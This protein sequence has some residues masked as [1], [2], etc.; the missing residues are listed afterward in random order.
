MF[1]RLDFFVKRTQSVNGTIHIVSHAKIEHIEFG[2]HNQAT[3]FRSKSFKLNGSSI[4]TRCKCSDRKA[5][6]KNVIHFV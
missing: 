3:W 4:R 5:A 2:N 6:P 1:K